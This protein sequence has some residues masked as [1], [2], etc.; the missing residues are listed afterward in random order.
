[1]TLRRWWLVL[2][3]GAIALF[4][5]RV[6]RPGAASAQAGVNWPEIELTGAVGGLERPVHITHA[7]DGSG[8][9]FVVE[10]V[11]RIRIV[12]GGELR[13]RPFLDIGDRV[14]CCGERGLLSVAFPRGYA[15]K[16]YFYINY[17]DTNGNTVVSRY[18]VTDDPD[19]ADASSEEIILTVD[20]PY[21]NHNGGQLAFGPRDGYLYI[22][23]GD[24]GSAGDPENRAQNP[25]ELLGKLLRIDVESPGGGYRIPTTNPFTQTAGYRPEIWALGLR[26]PWRFSFDRLTG[27]L[28]I[29]D[30]G[31]GAYEEI[32]YQP[33]SS[34]GGE[35][36]GWD[37][38]E[39]S[40][41]YSSPE[42]DRTGL[43]LPVVDYERAGGQCA[44]TGGYVYRGPGNPN[45]HGVYFYADYCSGRMWG[46]K[47]EEGTW[48]STVLLD[49]GF[50]ITSFGEDQIGN[51]YVTDYNSGAIHQVQ[52][53]GRQP[54]TP[55]DRL[56]ACYPSSGGL[57]SIV[58]W[59]RCLSRPGG[60]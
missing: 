58:R 20:Q 31:Q 12:A 48:H 24:G 38:M 17:T 6:V 30:V 46:L 9:L 19:L 14:S 55:L 36:Y 54:R 32:D 2:L 56:E 37:L 44:V 33:A 35:N 42:C 13:E 22:G 15:E 53:I 8:R 5:I 28:Y 7:G 16:G 57:F 10:Q 3:V 11:G 49:T 47:R 43:V 27:D 4:L 59:V 41:C 23:M 29:G 45:M 40:H 51:L 34:G 21:P 60:T 25:A 1:M 52:E 50:S 39:G 18:R 26:N